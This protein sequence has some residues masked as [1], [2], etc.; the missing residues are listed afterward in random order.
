MLN[1]GMSSLSST[2]HANAWPS[3]FTTA[4]GSA[5]VLSYAGYGRHTSRGGSPAPAATMACISEPYL[6][7]SSKA[8]DAAV[9]S[10]DQRLGSLGLQAIKEATHGQGVQAVIG[11]CHGSC[12]A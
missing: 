6:D 11:S 10:S 5:H 9:Q 12:C 4:A 2:H 3:C 1:T 8:G 7:L